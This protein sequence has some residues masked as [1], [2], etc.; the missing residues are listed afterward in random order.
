MRLEP[1]GV[2]ASDVNHSTIEVVCVGAVSFRT[3]FGLSAPEARIGPV[4]GLAALVERTSTLPP[5]PLTCNVTVET[6]AGALN[7]R[8][9]PTAGLIPEKSGLL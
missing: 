3:V 8:T 5:V 9:K 4:V 6:V 7:V 1:S 2:W